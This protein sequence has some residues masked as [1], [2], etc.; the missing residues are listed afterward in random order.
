[1]EP[2]ESTSFKANI[3]TRSIANSILNP[4]IYTFEAKNIL[5]PIHW[6][7]LAYQYTTQTNMTG[8]G[9]YCFRQNQDY[10]QAEITK[11]IILL[12]GARI[13][14]T[15]SSQNFPG[16]ISSLHC[17]QLWSI[18]SPKPKNQSV[19]FLTYRETNLY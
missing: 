15:T 9:C 18:P 8:M 13:K 4:F 6:Q 16:S 10:G 12:F 2:I 17:S 7:Q 11:H 5:V 19:F 14:R 1:M 3:T